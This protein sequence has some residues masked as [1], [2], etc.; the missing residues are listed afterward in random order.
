M[1]SSIL[2]HLDGDLLITRRPPTA[3]ERRAETK[4][5]GKANGLREIRRLFVSRWLRASAVT[6]IDSPYLRNRHRLVIESPSHLVRA[7]VPLISVHGKCMGMNLGIFLENGNRTGFPT[8][9][10]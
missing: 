6:E 2:K 5:R 7:R 10:L 8:G 4:V 9:G 3:G 1:S